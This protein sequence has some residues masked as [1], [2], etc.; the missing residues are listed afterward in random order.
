MSKHKYDVVIV[1]GA[2]TGSSVAYFL[3][4]NPDFHG[5][6]AIIEKDPTF[7]KAATALSASSIRHQFSNAVNVKMSQF[8]TQFIQES[9]QYLTVGE[10]KPDLEFRE[11][12]YLFLAATDAQE[13][14]LRNNHEVQT[15]CG[16]DVVLL[17]SS[18]LAAAFPH[19]SVSDIQLASYGRSGEGWFSNTGLMDAFK[20]K[21]RQ[22]GAELIIGEVCDLF[23]TGGK[24]TGV[25]L[26]NG[27]TIGCDYL[28][29][30]S[31]TRAAQ[32]AAMGSMVLPV[33][34]R[35]RM[36][37]V[38]DCEH[39]PQGTATVNNG[40]LPLMIDVTGTFCRPEGEYFM[41]GMSP[42]DDQA[43][44]PEDF[45]PR[46]E[47]FDLIWEQLAKRSKYFETIRLMNW[48]TGHYDYNTLDQNAIIGP[49]SEIKN[50]LF[51]NGFSGHGLQQSPAVGRG[52]SE[53]IIYGE[54]RALDLSELGYDRIVRQQPLVENAI[55]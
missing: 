49:H 46:Y 10:V 1:G 47:E 11:N 25:A 13:Q 36:I 28:V 19:L 45:D 8:G 32:I 14:I 39:S 30:T 2:V 7:Q 12:G 6:V 31:G 34:P 37:F 44:D 27:D 40:R 38:F 23:I 52:I 9:A 50:F 20:R 42:E 5:T 15:S 16:A 21:A 22:L 54:Y 53:C 18:E 35:R 17:N 29:N 26:A 3:T 43:V 41:T 51:A 33:E 55:I 48:W 4:S 24:V